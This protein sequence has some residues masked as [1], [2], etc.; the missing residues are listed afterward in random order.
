MMTNTNA[1]NAIYKIVTKWWTTQ[2]KKIR[3]SIMRMQGF[4]LMLI[5]NAMRLMLLKPSTA[6]RVKSYIT[7]QRGER[8]PPFFS[9]DVVRHNLYIDILIKIWYN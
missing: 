4:M 2:R 9:C 1:D 8:S 3:L 6:S 5:L 7:I